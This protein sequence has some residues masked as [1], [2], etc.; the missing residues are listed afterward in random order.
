VT[1]PSGNDPEGGVDLVLRKNGNTLLVQCK[2][3]KA[4]KVGVKVLRE[5]YG[6]MIDKKAHGAIIVTSGLF[7]Q[8]ARTFAAGKPIDLIE[9]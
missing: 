9:G 5:L 4:W 6:V 7:T 1:R 2:H 8:E 3:W